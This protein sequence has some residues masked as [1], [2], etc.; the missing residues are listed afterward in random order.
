MTTTTHNKANNDEDEDEDEDDE[1][2]DIDMDEDDDAKDAYYEARDELE[3]AF[4]SALTLSSDVR[5]NICDADVE[6]RGTQTSTE[7]A[8]AEQSP[9][10][11]TH[12]E[13]SQGKCDDAMMLVVTFSHGR[14]NYLVYS[15]SR[16]RQRAATSLCSSCSDTTS[17]QGGGTPTTTTSDAALN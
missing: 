5:V 17:C 10:R 3:T 12:N 1:D 9:Q 2:I 16:K 8:R 14:T 4:Q 6:Q 15:T 13:C 11:E 7:D